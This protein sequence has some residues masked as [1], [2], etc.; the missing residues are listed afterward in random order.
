MGCGG[1]TP[2]EYFFLKSVQQVKEGHTV[3]GRVVCVVGWGLGNGLF[4]RDGFISG[5]LSCDE[6]KEPPLFIKPFF[7]F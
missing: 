3:Y 6:A 1:E 2:P 4:C 7:S 5:P